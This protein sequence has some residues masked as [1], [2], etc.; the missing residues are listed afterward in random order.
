MH[1]AVCGLRH[2]GT[3]AAACL[4]EAGHQVTAW[5]P[6]PEQII[7]EPDL[8]EL[9]GRATTLK[10]ANAPSDC[11]GAD[12]VWITFDTPLMDGRADVDAVFALADKVLMH[13]DHNQLVLVSSQLPVGSI[14]KFQAKYPH[15]HFACSPE[16]LRRGKAVDGFKNPGRVII[17]TI[18]RANSREKLQTLFAPFCTNLIWVSVESAEFIKH[19]LNV[20]LGMSIAFANELGNIAIKHGASPV[21]VELGLKSDERIGQKAYVKYGAG[22]LGPH[23]SRDLNYLCEMAPESKLLWG[24]KRASE[25]WEAARG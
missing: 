15:L 5:D 14:A 7:G 1:V 19:A 12:V 18:D 3:V 4:A 17:G 13:C 22:G 8:A 9:W 6:A 16:N 25:E 21:A 2:L 23:L 20:F 10:R 24:I 11:A